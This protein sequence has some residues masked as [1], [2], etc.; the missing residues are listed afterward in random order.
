[1]D[2]MLIQAVPAITGFFSSLLDWILAIAKV[3]KW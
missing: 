3:F 1:M 2:D